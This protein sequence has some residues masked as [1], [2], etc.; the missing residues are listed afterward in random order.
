MCLTTL[1][2]YL[3]WTPQGYGSSGHK[4]RARKKEPS[5]G[6]S[7]SRAVE[8]GPRVGRCLSSCPI[9]ATTEAE[10]S[11]L[12]RTMPSEHTETWFKPPG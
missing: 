3:C 4:V 10:Y 12:G 11:P 6:R 2:R 8:S 9:S 1:T 5:G 7:L